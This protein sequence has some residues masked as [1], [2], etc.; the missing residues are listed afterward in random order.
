MITTEGIEYEDEGDVLFALTFEDEI[1]FTSK[2][3]GH[4]HI[5]KS[6]KDAEFMKS[7]AKWISDINCQIEEVAVF[8]QVR[9]NT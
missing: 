2:K 6:R 1:L 3:G 9:K 5:Y 7:M 8:R 4:A